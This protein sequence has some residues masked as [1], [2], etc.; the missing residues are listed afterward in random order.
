MYA[1][2]THIVVAAGSG[3]RFGSGLPKQF[4]LLDG[5]PVVMH[6]IDALRRATP[7]A[8]VVLV[9]SGPMLG[10]WRELCE[11][12]GFESPAVAFG[13]ASR[14]ESVR[15]GLALVSSD[16]TIVAI[17][18]GAR[19]LVTPEV[20]RAV[21]DE[22]AAGAQG[23]V[24]AVPVTDSLRRL[25]C[26]APSHGRAVDRSEYVAV[27]TPQAFRRDLLDLAYS[28]PFQS[29]FTDDASVM[30][31]AGF[32]DLRLTPGSPVNIKITNPDDLAVAEIILSRHCQ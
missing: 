20:V 13:G 14:W 26:D 4:C 30:E 17:H 29:R 21:V 19:P 31:A 18:D 11:R 16:C 24:P 15:N 12:H 23:A 32:T 5:R 28:R 2:T 25:E 7:G 8:P 1:G 6:A 3:S 27:Q 10:M 9:I 22:V